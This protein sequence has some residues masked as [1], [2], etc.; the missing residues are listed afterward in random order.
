M[1]AA[2]HRRTKRGIAG[3]RLAGNLLAGI[4]L[5]LA[6][7]GALTGAGWPVIGACLFGGLVAHLADLLQRWRGHP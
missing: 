4:C 6:V 7:R 1:L 5:A 3:A 2:Y